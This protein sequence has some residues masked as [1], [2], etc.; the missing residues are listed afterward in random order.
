MEADIR[1][2]L[3]DRA[4]GGDARRRRRRCPPWSW[5]GSCPSSPSFLCP[6]RRIGRPALVPSLRGVPLRERRDES[7]R[8]RR[9]GKR[10]TREVPRAGRCDEATGGDLHALFSSVSFGKIQRLKTH[11]VLVYM[12]TCIKFSPS[13]RT[14]RERTNVLRQ[15]RAHI[16]YYHGTL[17]KRR[18]SSSSIRRVR[19]AIILC[20][21]SDA[22]VTPAAGHGAPRAHRRALVTAQGGARRRVGSHPPGG[23]VFCVG[24]RVSVASRARGAEARGSLAVVGDDA[25]VGRD[26]S[27]EI[28]LRHHRRERGPPP[29]APR[30]APPP[31]RGDAP[32]PPARG[33]ARRL[34]RRRRR[35]RGDLTA[36]AAARATDATPVSGLPGSSV[37]V[38]PPFLRASALDAA[39]RARAPRS[40]VARRGTSSPRRA[41]RVRPASAER[42]STRRTG[43][44]AAPCGRPAGTEPRRASRPPPSAWRLGFR[45]RTPRRTAGREAAHRAASSRPPGRAPHAGGDRGAPA[46]THAFRVVGGSFPREGAL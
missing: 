18:Y 23:V 12:F 45:A 26:R 8:A 3:G 33:R 40:A 28:A 32:P 30:L 7:T 46:A 41:R 11:T 39:A 19:S 35:L 9:A 31:A 42:R 43:P 21:A 36:A 15:L 16:T 17:K 38:T 13:R 25:R 1:E 22:L 6:S 5:T 20:L 34:P 4:H 14:G 37:M 29:R 10:R 2:G 24:A 27:A 44:R